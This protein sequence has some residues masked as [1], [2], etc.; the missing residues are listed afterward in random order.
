MILLI[1]TPGTETPSTTLHFDAKVCINLLFLGLW[2]FVGCMQGKA[3][4]V[5]ILRV[6]VTLIVLQFTW[7]MS[8]TWIR[9]LKVLSPC[10]YLSLA[11]NPINFNHAR[12]WY[13]IWNSES[14]AKRLAHFQALWQAL[15]C[16]QPPVSWLWPYCRKRK[17]IDLPRKTQPIQLWPGRRFPE[18][19]APSIFQ[20]IM[21]RL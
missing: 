2:N 3:A 19:S 15:Q 7:W 20:R 10:H 17:I 14:A 18:I 1:Q 8:C 5:L 9:A 12:W 4:R 6:S 13:S 21:G 11:G 16:Q